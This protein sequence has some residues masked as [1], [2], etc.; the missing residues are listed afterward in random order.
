MEGGIQGRERVEPSVMSKGPDSEF[1]DICFFGMNAPDAAPPVLADVGGKGVNLCKLARANFSV[2]PGFIV[3]TGE[4]RQFIA[5]NGLGDRIRELAGSLDATNVSAL[6]I[7]SAE[8][9]AL[10]DENPIP[11]ALADRIR[12]S[13]RLLRDSGGERVAV[14]SSATAE[15]LPEASFAGQ[16]DT[17]LNIRGE[18][19]LLKAVR[20]CWGSLWTDRA[21]AYRARQKTSLE[22]LAMAVVVQ[23]MV[24]AEAA[25]VMFTANPVTGSADEIVINATWGLGEAIVGGH[26][27]PDT[28]VVDKAS[29]NVKEITVSEKAVMTAMTEDGTRETEIRTDRR[30]AR[31][32]DDAAV[33]RLAA[34][35]REIESHY[36]APQDIEWALA[37]GQFTVLQARPIQGLEVARDVEA[38][39]T[40]EIQ[41]LQSLAGACRRVWVAHNLAETLPTP[42][43][44][45]WE[46]VRKFM[47]GDGGFGRM[48]KDFG[49]LPSERVRKEGFLELICGRIYADPDRA[50]G[51]FW[52]AMPMEYD[53]DLVLKDKNALEAPPSRFNAEK[54][55]G[56]FLL[57]LPKTLLAMLRSMWRMNR[58]RSRVLERFEKQIL[59]PFLD[60]VKT[61]RS[62][63]LKGLPTAEVIEELH[64]R[65]RR[66]MDDFGNE[67]L[68]PSFFGGMAR[69][70]LEGT[71][72]QLMGEQAGRELTLNLTM[73]LL[74]D[75]TLEQNA[76]LYAVAHG[77]A[78]M[79]Q[80]IE[81]FGHRAAGEMELAEPRWREDQSYLEK[82]L[83][84]FRLGDGSNAP[85]ATHE[86]H[87]ELR[88]EAERTLPDLLA[89]WGGSSLRKDI[90]A[91]MREAQQ[92]LPYR[93]NGKYYLMLGYETI[94][95]ALLE[96]ARRWRLGRDVF[97][98]HLDELGSFE[99]QRDERLQQIARRKI[100]WQAARRLELTEVLNS[101]ELDNL[102]KPR[103]Y[104][105]A[106][107]LKGDPVAAG[108][109]T[110]TARILRDPKDSRDIGVSYVLV[111][112]STDPGWTALFVN[113]RGL[114]IERGGVLSHGAIVARDFGIPAVVCPDATRR[115][116]DGATI[117]VDGNRGAITIVDGN[118]R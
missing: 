58:M 107:E 33:R 94:R 76:M 4:Y 62:Q 80:F 83:S 17:Y 90:E 95:L 117:R 66:V 6:T 36:G 42:T 73:G 78:T 100:R 77:T 110:G 35:G 106:S 93:E 87:V 20:S 71:L 18:E 49:Y 82:I 111:C 23:K 21:V 112:P 67:S 57:R 43:P 114:V 96:L 29:G 59:P 31:V 63:D 69:A 60:Y 1:S 52:E 84:G 44:L 88:M 3:P 68:Q 28:I 99:A 26:V 74:G 72:I 30:L 11:S 12:S 98:L 89:K 45:T 32:L 37:V 38:C 19:A 40:E 46:I 79:P 7:A 54:A 27:T 5:H 41:R 91:D 85:E 14:R 118:T 10:F 92:L 108:I 2:P 55:D 50:A 81:R 97:F 8:I 9:R 103:V 56:T 102:G 115:I 53:L 61:R 51:L 24:A 48:Y 65:C 70:A 47:S 86:K 25:G 113:A 101:Q 109:F 104:E 34:V 75:L 16:Q 64:E 116:K 105:A 15:D 39:R 13:Y 22:G